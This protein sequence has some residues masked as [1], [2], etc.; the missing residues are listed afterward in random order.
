MQTQPTVTT[1]RLSGRYTVDKASELFSTLSTALAHHSAV[2]IDLS[3]VE[4]L[5]LSALQLFYA[6]ARSARSKGGSLSFVGTV[7]DKVCR[8]LSGA[9]FSSAGPLSGKEFGQG[10]PGFAEASR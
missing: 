5:E 6:A 3:G 2:Q 7:S 9:G 8:R 4:E 1:L 10:L